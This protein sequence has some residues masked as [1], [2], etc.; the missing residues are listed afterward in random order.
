MAFLLLASRYQI[1]L[2]PMN[3]FFISGLHGCVSAQKCT[4]LIANHFGAIWGTANMGFRVL[5]NSIP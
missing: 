2:N 5:G 3:V 1:Q 4:E